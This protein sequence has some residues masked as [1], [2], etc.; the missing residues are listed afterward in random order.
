MYFFIFLIIVGVTAG[1]LLHLLYGDDTYD[2]N[3]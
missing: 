1:I 3:L 2:D